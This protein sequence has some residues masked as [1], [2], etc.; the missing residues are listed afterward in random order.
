MQTSRKVDFRIPLY[1][2]IG[3]LLAWA[4]PY[5]ISVMRPKSADGWENFANSLAD[6][7]MIYYA[8][9]GFLI[10]AVVSSAFG[11]YKSA[12]GPRKKAFTWVFGISLTALIGLLLTLV[13][14]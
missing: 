5:L 6:L 4:I 11:W 10:I 8:V 2:L 14:P 12:E 9:M 1:Y 7:L 3:G 13:S